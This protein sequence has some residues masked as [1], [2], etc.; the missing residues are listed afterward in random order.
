MANQ[1]NSRPLSFSV[2]QVTQKIFKKRG[3][4][5]AGVINDWQTIVGH[6]LAKNTIPERLSTN[7][8]LH[9][10]VDAPLATEIQHLEPQIIEKIAGYFG[11]R[12]VTRIRIIRGP[13]ENKR[14]QSKR[15]DN[16]VTTSTTSKNIYEQLSNTQKPHIKSA[17]HRLGK[18][19]SKE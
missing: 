1:N 14:E 15:Q 3:F 11:Y 10:R 19:V 2:Q 9:L 13:I 16:N 7:G 6:T 17:L 12:A 4:S 18:T 8:I 5:A